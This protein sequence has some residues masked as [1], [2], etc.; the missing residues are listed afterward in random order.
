MSSTDPARTPAIEA[1]E[2]L[3][4]ILRSHI[5]LVASGSG[6]EEQ[7]EDVDRR[8]WE[9]VGAYGDALDELFEEPEE[10][11][12]SEGADEIRVTVRTRFDYTVADEK[13]LLGSSEGIGAAVGR[14]IEKHGA[15]LPALEV[16]SLE[17]GSGVVTVHLGGEPLVAADFDS[18]EEP[19]D[20]L[21]VA[22]DERLAFVIDSPVY[23]SRAEAEAAAKRR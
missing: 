6:S 20:L 15:P 7:A 16:D 12:E 17:R 23:D 18:A 10:P 1:G 21:L 11:D 22:P 19:T 5:D 13:A 2:A 8:L 14:L 4:E 3:L 9:A